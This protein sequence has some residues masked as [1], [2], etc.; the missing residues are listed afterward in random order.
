LCPWRTWKHPNPHTVEKSFILARAIDRLTL[1]LCT[2]WIFQRSFATFDGREFDTH[3]FV[4][5]FLRE[6]EKQHSLYTTFHACRSNTVA[7]WMNWRFPVN[8]ASS[9]ACFFLFGIDTT[10]TVVQALVI[11][12]SPRVVRTWGIQQSRQSATSVLHARRISTLYPQPAVSSPYSSRHFLPKHTSFLYDSFAYSSTRLFSTVLSSSSEIPPILLEYDEQYDDVETARSGDWETAHGTSGDAMQSLPVHSDEEFHDLHP[13]ENYD[14]MEIAHVGDTMPSLPIPSDEDSQNHQSHENEINANNKI[15]QQWDDDNLFH[16]HGIRSRPV[17]GG[18]WNPHD[19]LH[20]TRHWGR[21]SS[22]YDAHV[23]ALAQQPPDP[24]I[25]DM[26]LPG[27]TLVRTLAQAQAVLERL[28]AA[29]PATTVHACDT[30]VMDIDLSTVGPV[31]H[32]YVTCMSMYA[33][34]QFDYGDGPGTTLWIDNLD[35]AFGVLQEFKDFL[36]DARIQKVWHNYGFDRH[37]L[38][39]EGINCQGLHGDTMH[40][41]RLQNTARSKQAGGNGYALEALTSRFINRRKKPMKELFGVKR[42]RKDGSEGTLVDIPPVEVLQR[43][44]Q[45]RRSWI[46]YSCYDAQGTYLLFQELK[47]LLTD[48]PWRVYDQVPYSLYDYYHLHMRPF[49]EVLTDM[50]RRGVRVDARDY[51]A[52]VEEQAREDRDGHSRIFRDWASQ[53]IGADGLAI[54]P[55]SSLQLQTFLFGGAKIEKTDEVWPAERVFKVPRDEIPPE[56]LEAYKKREE[57]HESANQQEGRK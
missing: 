16:T 40:M 22:D 20:W 17:P 38:W 34:P 39:N 31:G 46:E 25:H 30:E 21:R 51:L 11:R 52:K 54:N 15:N 24:A 57:E 56:A 7:S 49:A 4:T 14:N 6:R 3:L 44:P 12:R 55:A 33:G 23:Q 35:D 8:F 32:G 2:L 5:S 19:P 43:D 9:L 1:V 29:D 10:M 28:Y 26:V 47:K 45:F 42:T 41:A 13:V 48:K 50:E 18:M 36:E 27:V 53:Y 37:V